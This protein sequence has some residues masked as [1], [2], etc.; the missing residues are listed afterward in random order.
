M[1]RKKRKKL[2]ERRARLQRQ[3]DAELRRCRARWRIRISAVDRLLRAAATA[4]DLPAQTKPSQASRVAASE[5]ALEGKVN[6]ARKK[7]VME[8]VRQTLRH[9][10]GFFTVRTLVQF[11]NQTRPFSVTER[12]I[13]H[14]LRTL[15]R[16]G[17]IKLVERGY[18][19][20]PHMYFKS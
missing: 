2:L 4:D 10:Q 12:E 16:L 18:G 11:I 8:V 6:G 1:D 20:K 7:C 5:N 19:R 15:R 9:N 17:E 14:P 3:R 13:N